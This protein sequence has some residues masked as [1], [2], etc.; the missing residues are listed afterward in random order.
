MWISRLGRSLAARTAILA[1]LYFLTG[2]LGLLLAV[3]PGYATVIWPASGIAVG[4]LLVYGPRLWGG[5]LI[6]SFL[7]NSLNSGGISLEGGVDGVKLLTALGIAVGSTIQAL[8]GRWLVVRFVGLPLALNGVRSVLTLL[9]LSGPAACMIAAS[10]GVGTLLA[11]GIISPS[12]VAGNWLTWWLGDVLGVL[13]FLPLALAA[14]GNP[15]PPTWRGRPLA[16][17]SILTILVLIVPLVLTFYAW[18]ITAEN[19]Y[20]QRRTE[21]AALA[22]E[23][24]DALRFRMTSY[25]YA[26]LGA[27][28]YYQS[29]EGLSRADWRAYV[30]T[31]NVGTR[32]PGINGIGVILP[33]DPAS[34]DDFVARMRADGAPEFRIHPDAPGRPLNVI[35]YIEPVALNGPA[36]GLN[37]G[38][39]DNRLEAARLSRGSGD[40]AITRKIILVQDDQQTPGFLMLRP[41]YQAGAPTGT[42]EQRDA[43]LRAWVYAPFIARNLLADL[44]SS[45]GNSLD[46]KVY[47]GTTESD[48]SL[49]YDSANSRESARTP[50]YTV[51]RPVTIM[52]QTWQVVWTS[53]PAYEKAHRS[54]QPLMVLVGGLLFT[55][56]FGMFVILGAVRTT[57]TMEWLL[58]EQKYAGPVLVFLIVA[59]GAFYLFD[60]A[61]K[62]EN[63]FVQ[64][65]VREQADKIAL[66]V[67]VDSR[68]RMMA[69][70]RMGRRWEATGG[71]NQ[72]EWRADADGFVE[73]FSG[74]RAVEWIDDSYH[75]RW[76]Q[77]EAGNEAAVNLN[78]LFNKERAEA[79]TDAATRASLTLTPPLDL[80]QGYRAI[81]AYSPLHQDGKFAGFLAAV[82]QTDE[83]FA[84]VL[85]HEITDTYA[86]SISHE[87]RI[88]YSSE[89]EGQRLAPILSVSR[90]IRVAD[91]VWRL[92]VT[93]TTVVVRSQSSFLPIMLLI[94]GLMIAALLALTMRAILLAKVKSAYLVRS[95]RL[96]D[97]ILSSSAF[98]IIATDRDGTVVLFNRAAEKA[99][100]YDAAEVVGLMNP[101][102]WHD[103][104]EVVARAVALGEE[105]G[106]PVEPGF[107]VFTLKAVRDG[108]E[109]RQWTYIGKAGDRFPVSLTV[110]PLRDDTGQI[111][112]YLGV[113]ENVTERLE[114]QRALQNSE[115]TFRAAMEHA[116]IGMGLG[117]VTGGWLKV[118]P[119]LCKLFGYSMEELLSSDLRSLTHPDDLPAAVAL[120]RQVIAGEISRYQTERRY[121]HRSGRII[122]ALVNASLVRDADG[123]PKYFVIQIQ[124][125]TDRKEMDRIKSEFISV[126]SHE[127][128]TP[129]TSIRGSLGLVVGTMANEL[130]TKVS[131]LLEIAANNCERLILLINDILDIDKLA[132]GQM[133]FNVQTH[134]VDWLVGQAVDANTA[135]AAN[136]KVDL[137]VEPIED[138]LEVM[139]DADR[140]VQV[141]SNLISN[142]AKFSP[143]GG[144]V[145]L[146]AAGKASGRVR[147]SVADK[148][149]GI[150][151]EFSQQIFG[152]FSQ[153]DSSMTRA[154]GGT[155]LGLHIS[156]QLIEQMGGEIGFD[157]QVGVGSTF[158][159]E[160]PTGRTVGGGSGLTTLSEHPREHA[161]LVHAGEIDASSPIG[162]TLA[163]AGYQVDAAVDAADVMARVEQRSYAA[164]IIDAALSATSGADL[165][166]D[167]RGLPAGADLP[168]VLLSGVGEP[169]P[170]DPDGEAPA[171]IIHDPDDRN[172]VWSVM[173]AVIG[174]DEPLPL[175]LHV[176]DDVDFSNFLAEA[177]QGKARLVAATTLRQAMRMVSKQDFAL[178]VLDIGLPDGD[179]LTLLPVLKDRG[180]VPIPV[181]ILSASETPESALP[182]VAVAMV[183]SRRSEAHIVETILGLI[184]RPEMNSGDGDD[185]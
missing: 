149:P 124:D 8:V 24:E 67:A 174:D 151:P 91:K 84:G 158:W 80:V 17:L 125:I 6:G 130:P 103:P 21:F 155:G 75:V 176:E 38:F 118:S 150:S 62:R 10:V 172:E 181:A 173:Q 113:A 76:V 43:G 78:I 34:Q 66:L 47:D 54:D 26:L 7:L 164:L 133:R 61:H 55:G 175:V 182:D 35:T 94:G 86:V 110:T 153:G 162:R 72:A 167:L 30:D 93:P 11:T 74:L 146:S 119:S 127:L 65:V 179:G 183:K 121:F 70:R 60:T 101:S 22:S 152:K 25:D 53:T 165:I 143:E 159:V 50:T 20:D 9:G 95:N 16:K 18:K 132:S 154:R 185:D 161:V 88:L 136:F 117:S 111:T 102:V 39:E 77:P 32:F 123:A 27:A 171:G 115:E 108:V 4:M 138:D 168:V 100:G 15:R 36:V 46:L 29:K 147:I 184:T 141:L 87:G 163:E 41:V 57:E 81:I 148:G 139:V 45:Q 157:T 59:S 79:L 96:N 122:W 63:V 89:P 90:D 52:Q 28:G 40:P 92:T 144:A 48:D 5:V 19:V 82:F 170:D 178:V 1:I 12:E 107:P 71:T 97:A 2:K 37:T 135:Y 126:V 177:M 42:V 31:L 166:R 49:I 3:P 105:L 131:R 140:L 156:R 51:R 44:T 14:P 169:T 98:L 23:S 58:K 69:L 134:Q 64:D 109:S 137:A 112:G 68:D 145:T 99:L 180:G 83:F 116:P 106:R 120:R 129:L 114:H 104:E 73:Q 13:V 85:G 33:V 142:A 128:R 56:L 160:V